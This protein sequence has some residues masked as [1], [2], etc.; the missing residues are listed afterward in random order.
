MAVDTFPF[1]D[2]PERPLGSLPRRER[3][4]C[5]RG[6]AGSLDEAWGLWQSQPIVC[7]RGGRIAVAVKATPPGDPVPAVYRM[8]CVRCGSESPWF[9]LDADGMRVV[10]DAIT[11][12]TLPVAADASDD[13]GLID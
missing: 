6:V 12:P 10:A 4:S 5:W 13:E 2:E 3:A 7:E 1:P 11:S 8:L 9:E